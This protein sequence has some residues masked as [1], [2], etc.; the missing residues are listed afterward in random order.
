MKDT[1]RFKG[2]M[3]GIYATIAVLLLFALVLAD[4]EI[5]DTGINTSGT[6][7]FD[8]ISEYTAAAGVTIDSVVLKD[9]GITLT[10]NLQLN[11]DGYDKIDFIDSSGS[12]RI[13]TSTYFDI[14]SLNTTN[15]DF[16]VINSSST[17]VFSVDLETGEMVLQSTCSGSCATGA[18]SWNTSHI[19]VCTTTNT[20]ES[21]A[22]S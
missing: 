18:I 8:T 14:V 13:G 11:D 19:C 22:I 9:G 1:A 2:F 10:D 12:H 15:Q 16:R 6:V 20:W 4:T 21:V 3:Q 5:S 7:Y 17:T